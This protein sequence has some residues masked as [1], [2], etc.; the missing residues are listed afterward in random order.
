MTA[1]NPG[2]HT[3]WNKELARKRGAALGG[4]NRRKGVNVMLG[5]VVGPAW[6]VV[7]GGRNWEG[8]SAD[9]YLSGVLAAET[10]RGVQSRGVMTSV[11]VCPAWN[12]CRYERMLD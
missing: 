5:P 7:K 11:K 3:S 6:T 4:E 1:A 2:S 12:A 9:P 8:A 10:V